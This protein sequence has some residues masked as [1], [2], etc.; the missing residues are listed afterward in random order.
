MPQS[1]LVM[2]LVVSVR[3]LG[4]SVVIAGRPGEVA[5]AFGPVFDGFVGS[6]SRLIDSVYSVVRRIGFQWV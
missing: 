4:A 3:S 1:S 2:S 5:K 6:V